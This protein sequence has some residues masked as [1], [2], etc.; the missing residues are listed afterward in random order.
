MLGNEI[1]T[2]LNAGAP[3][4]CEAATRF[5][6][7]TQHAFSE[8]AAVF[9]EEQETVG[10]LVNTREEILKKLNEE[11]RDST[12]TI[13]TQSCPAGK[14]PIVVISIKDQLAVVYRNVP[15]RLLAN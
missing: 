5:L 15:T 9:L 7:D 3:A 1:A 6:E 8:I 2:L 14:I 10:V 11:F 4:F 12:I 13:A